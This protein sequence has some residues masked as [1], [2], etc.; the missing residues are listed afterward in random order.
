MT[1]YRIQVL[2]GAGTKDEAW[3]DVRPSGGKPYEYDDPLT[4]EN[5]LRL[6]YDADPSMARVIEK[7]D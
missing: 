1:K 4:A 5:M 2:C 3:R 6:C 7:E